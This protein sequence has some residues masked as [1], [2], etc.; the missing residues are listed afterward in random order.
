[1]GRTRV[2]EEAQLQSNLRAWNSRPP[3]SSPTELS[4]FPMF[5][6]ESTADALRVCT[7]FALSSRNLLFRGS[8]SSSL[9]G[10]RNVR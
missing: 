1:M 10:R 2:T 9:T 5:V 3:D 7:T 8:N 6:C 4:I